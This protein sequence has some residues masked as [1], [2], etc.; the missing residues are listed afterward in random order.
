MVEDETMEKLRSEAI[1]VRSAIKA[2]DLRNCGFTLSDFPK[3]SCHHAVKLLAFHLSELGWSK[4]Q[5]VTGTRNDDPRYPHLWLLAGDVIIDITADQFA[6]EGQPPVTVTR[7]SPW[8]ETW[9]FKAEPFDEKILAGWR[10]E[11]RDDYEVYR[12][13]MANLGSC[14]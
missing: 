11:K 14:P 6:G 10:M 5:R 2:T 9:K 12:K 1:L 4:L 13:I 3:S 7:R 8:H